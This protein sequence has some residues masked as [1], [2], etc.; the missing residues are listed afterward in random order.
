[1]T[2]VNH[3]TFRTKTGICTITP[4]EIILTR[5]GVRGEA[6]ESLMGSGSIRGRLILFAFL[7]ASLLAVGG[8][9]LSRKNIGDAVVPTALGVFLLV[10]AIRSRNNTAA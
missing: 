10:D 6:A 5:Q 1:M 7:G 8:F 2:E 9:Y 3:H 4:E